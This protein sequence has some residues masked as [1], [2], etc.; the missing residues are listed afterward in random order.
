M[1]QPLKLILIGLGMLL[2]GVILPFMIILELLES[3]LF[4]N[5][6]TITS[7]TGGLIIG[8]MGIALHVR[9]RR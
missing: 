5:F 4:L 9:A 7:S 3:T 2:L 8:F 1:D 6:L